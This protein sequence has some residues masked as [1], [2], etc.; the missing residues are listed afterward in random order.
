MI[1]ADKTN[2]IK[3]GIVGI[4]S[5]NK[6]YDVFVICWD[7]LKYHRKTTREEIEK[8]KKMGFLKLSKTK[9]LIFDFRSSNGV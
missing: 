7:G 4:T 1:A 2:L 5:K 6:T 9:N 3:N 8:Y